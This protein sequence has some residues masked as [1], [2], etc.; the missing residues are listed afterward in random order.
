MCPYL[1]EFIEAEPYA[2]QPPDN[3][4]DCGSV[5]PAIAYP[6]YNIA[7]CLGKTRESWSVVWRL[8]LRSSFH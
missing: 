4:V 2:F 1:C 7:V 3:T 6:L 8:I 5:G